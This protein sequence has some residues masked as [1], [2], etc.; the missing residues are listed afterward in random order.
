MPPPDDVAAH[1]DFLKDVY[2]AGSTAIIALNDAAFLNH[3]E[4]DLGADRGST[5]SLG[6]RDGTSY[7]GIALWPAVER[8][9]TAEFNLTFM[10]ALLSS[11]V[12]WIG[13][14]LATEHFF[15]SR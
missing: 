8:A 4:H 9:Q 5:L 13:D 7:E 6:R 1:I 15:D 11:A 3:L 14:L 2:V 10:G 12:S